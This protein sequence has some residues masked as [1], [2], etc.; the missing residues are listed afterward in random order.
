M[1]RVEVATAKMKEIW[2]TSVLA[3]GSARRDETIEKILK[4]G[5]G[6]RISHESGGMGRDELFTFTVQ[7]V[8]ST[9]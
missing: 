7:R 2:P 3:S 4:Y 9:S 8:A 6:V 1:D 5:G